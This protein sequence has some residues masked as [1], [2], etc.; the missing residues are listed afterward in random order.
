V[1]R[2]FGITIARVS[3]VMALLKL[4]PERQKELA[5]LQDQRAIR[6]FSERRLRSLLAIKDSSEQIREF[7]KTKERFQSGR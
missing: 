1:A 3:H 4:A 2:E 6:Y 5:A 7:N